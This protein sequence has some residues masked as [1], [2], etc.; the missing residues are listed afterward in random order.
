[1]TVDLGGQTALVTGG[2]TGLGLPIA[3][4]LGRAGARIALN[5]LTRERVERAC[6]RLGARGIAC[7]GLPADVRDGQAVSAMLA[8]VTGQWGAPDI[9]VANAGIYPN[10]PFL[11]LPEKEWDRVF[12]INVKGTFLTCQAAAREMVEAGRGTGRI[13]VI[14]S[15]AAKAAVSGW[16]HYCASKAAVAMLAQAMAL[17]L[18]EHGIRVNAVLPGYID[19]DE[20]GAHLDEAYKSGARSAVPLGRSGT[21]EDVANVVLL[22]VSPLADFVNGA[23]L[24]VDGGSG[25]GQPGV[26]PVDHLSSPETRDHLL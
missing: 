24:A 19:V 5:D 14:S 11:E 22:L 20:G 6:E 23:L 12:D 15:G 8:S 21:P 2:A 25:A 4:T 17:E 7:L 16:S 9:V 10:T 1:M 13:I 3:Q 18:G 26:R